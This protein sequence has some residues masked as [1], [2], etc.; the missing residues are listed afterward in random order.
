[1]NLSTEQKQTHRQN[2][3]V[4]AKGR[5]EVVGCT[6]SLILVDANYHIQNGQTMWSC[7]RAQAI[8]S[9]LLR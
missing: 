8:I 5:G 3:L 1:M 4:V 7:C 2:R 6:G 9:S